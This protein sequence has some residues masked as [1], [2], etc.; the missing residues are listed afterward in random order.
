MGNQ[1]AKCK[2]DHSIIAALLGVLVAVVLCIGIMAA[3]RS[4][5]PD[6]ADNWTVKTEETMHTREGGW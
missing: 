2:G 1:T 3:V 4:F 5:I 6:N